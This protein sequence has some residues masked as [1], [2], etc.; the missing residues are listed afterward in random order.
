V[1]RIMRK[2][3]TLI[4]LLVVI[5]IIAILAAILF[6]VFAKA[7]EK[8]RQSSCLSNVKQISLGVLQYCQDYDEAYPNVYN[9]TTQPNCYGIIQLLDPYTKNTQ[10][11]NCPSADQVSSLTMLGSRSYAY[12]LNLFPSIAAAPKMSQVLRPADIIM[13]SDAM[14]DGN[15]PGWLLGPSYGWLKTDLDGKNCQICGGTHNSMFPGTGSGHSWQ[16]PGCNFF[17]RHNGMGNVGFCDGHAKCLS[18]PAVYNNGVLAPMWN[19]N[20]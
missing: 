4:E 10:V 19:W 8:A 9:G 5:A 16:Q 7:R 11:H 18:Y 12:N 3:F 17:P 20:Q 6:P 1:Q 14:E 13:M 2:G 15:L